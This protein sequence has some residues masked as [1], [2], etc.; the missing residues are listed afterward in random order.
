MAIQRE[1]ALGI[2][3][4]L[5]REPAVA[6]YEAGVASAIK[7]VLSDLGLGFQVDGYG[8]IIVRVPG[9]DAD[10]A[11]I[12]FVAHMDH[13]GFEAFAAQGDCLVAKALGG[14][15]AASFSSGIR[16]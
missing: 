13:P 16:V 6:F 15:P 11:P 3:A 14:V 8:N 10:E 7:T 5:G 4:Q 12:A 2:L 1:Q 9:Q